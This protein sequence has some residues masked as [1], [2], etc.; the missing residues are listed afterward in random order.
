VKKTNTQKFYDDNSEKLIIQYDNAA[1]EHLHMLFEKYIN[2]EDT[3]LDV[4][5]GS[6]RDLKFIQTIS[7]NVFGFDSCDAFV[8]NMVG[9]E[10][11]GRVSK[12]KLPD[13]NIDKFQI[14]VDK[15]DIVILI[16]VLMHLNILEIEQSIENI[17]KVLTRKSIVIISY[18]LE[19][20]IVDERH[21]EPLTKEIMT[22][23]FERASFVNIDGFE[24][25]DVMN[26]NIEWVTQVF[27]KEN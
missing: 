22:N 25:Q 3:V 23:V 4:G 12:G 20:Q 27:R 7:P 19:R 8:Q 15:F 10:L 2:A 13:I 21:F 18:S 14:N 16:A 5:F 17:K 1:V 9:T 6:G 26:R 11:E 24:N